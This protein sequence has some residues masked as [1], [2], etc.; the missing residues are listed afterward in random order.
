NGLGGD[1][2][3]RRAAGCHQLHD[4][5]SQPGFRR[6]DVGSGDLLDA[7]ERLPGTRL[8]GLGDQEVFR[9][10]D[11]GKAGVAYV[12]VG[13]RCLACTDIDFSG[14]AATPSYGGVARLVPAYPQFDHNRPVQIRGEPKCSA[15][16]GGYSEYRHT[17][18][19]PAHFV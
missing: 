16:A 19:T 8:D 15:L 1:V 7:G 14:V 5:P 18:S 13:S 17:E 9:V 2:A 6:L 4:D 3:L 12:H 10:Q 11:A